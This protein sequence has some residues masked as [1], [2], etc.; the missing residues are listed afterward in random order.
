MTPNAFIIT[1]TD[2][3]VGKTLVSSVLLHGTNGTYWKPLQSGTP[4][5]FETVQQ[6]TGLPPEHFCPPV[7]SFKEPLSPHRAAELENVEIDL[8]RLQQLPDYQHGP[9]IIEGAGGVMVPI[10]RDYLQI[11]YFKA[12]GLPVIIVA[13]TQLGTINHTLLTIETLRTRHIPIAGIIFNGPPMPDTQQTITEI[14]DIP[15]IGHIFTL[16]HLPTSTDLPQLWQTSGLKAW[17][18][19]Q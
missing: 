15:Q 9:L 8:A 13:R 17:W 12:L 1:G 18:H 14:S 7:H 3:D 10:T 2:T 16:P 4:T 6:L 19:A 5:D 11:D